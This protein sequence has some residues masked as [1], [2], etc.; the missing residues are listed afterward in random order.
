MIIKKS[1]L[2]NVCDFGA[3]GDGKTVQTENIN[4]AI[5]KLSSEGGGELYFPSGT[6]LTGTVVL[7]SNVILNLSA[8]ARIRSTGDKGDYLP[9]E[10]TKNSIFEGEECMSGALIWGENLKNIGIIGQ[11]VIDGNGIK[12]T[13][14]KNAYLYTEGQNHFADEAC[15]YYT[16]WR[17]FTLKLFNCEN[18]TLKGVSFTNPASW[19]VGM[20]MC[21]DVFCDGLNIKSY[22]F[23]NGDGLDF[24]SCERVFVSNCTFD[25]TDDCIALQSAFPDKTCKNIQINNCYFKTLQAGIRVGMA[26]LGNFESICVSNCI[27]EDCACSG[28]KIQQCEGGKMENLIFRG[29]VMKNVARPFFF[30]HN[31]YECTAKSL[32]KEGWKFGE[33]GTL[34]NVIISDCII[35]NE[36][37]FENGGLI[38]DGEDGFVISDFII[39]NVMYGFCGKKRYEIEVKSLK[40]RRPEADVYGG[41]LCGELFFR[42]CENFII[43]NLYVS[44]S[45]NKNVRDALLKN[46]NNFNFEN[47]NIPENKITVKDSNNINIT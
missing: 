44:N 40:G 19:N 2:Y 23:F 28:L 7:K 45:D 35:N 20:T 26:C 8:G 36:K 17:P 3:I 38:F 34:K 22:N 30:T 47:C 39:E 31:A 24:C 14:G 42:N 25:C 15:G 11:G 1:T 4:S 12:L 46:C 6:Y 32:R 41:A 27:F 10:Q 5:D 18:V 9:D 43:K 13:A 29:L 16:S 21:Q 37:E 33:R